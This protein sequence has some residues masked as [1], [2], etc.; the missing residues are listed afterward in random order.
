MSP[1]RILAVGGSTRPASASERALLV[2]VAEVQR[3]GADVTVM[4][5]RDLMLP[6]YDTETTE[7]SEGAVRLVEAMRECD[8]LIVSCPAY[9]GTV[10]G[11]MKNALDYA[12]D[13]ATDSRPYLEG[14]AFGA[15][16]VAYGWQAAVS[17][18]VHLRGVGHALRAWPTPLGAS[19]N[20]AVT[21]LDDPDEPARTAL[22]TIAGQV[23]AFAAAH[24]AVAQ[25]PASR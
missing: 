12:E 16:S 25:T 23:V 10:S 4:V 13:L 3:L 11:M 2:A 22:T 7:R 9:H 6:L 1:K 14:R 5:G 17:T 24:G 20:A 19:L 15:I 18:L 21:D 8:G